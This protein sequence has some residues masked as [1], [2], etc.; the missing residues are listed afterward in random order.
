[1]KKNCLLRAVFIFIVIAGIVAYIVDK[2]GKEFYSEGKEKLTN[3]ALEKIELSIN[4][5]DVNNEVDSLQVLFDDFIYK[6]KNKEI[7]I[8]SDYYNKLL[9]SFEE[10]LNTGKIELNKLENI[11]TLLKENEKS[12]KN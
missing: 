11:N 8:D 2:Y 1:M 7:L 5:L 4:S 6:I 12:K 3:L 10:L 9:N